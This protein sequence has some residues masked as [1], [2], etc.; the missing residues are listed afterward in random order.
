M[1]ELNVRGIG[2]TTERFC[3]KKRALKDLVYEKR[4]L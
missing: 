4:G 1:Y 3:T 2:L